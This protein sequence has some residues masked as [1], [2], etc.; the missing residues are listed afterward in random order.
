MSRHDW[1]A[2]NPGCYLFESLGG[3]AQL[4]ARLVRIEKAR[5]SS[6]LTSTS[7]HG[8][9]RDGPFG[10]S[11]PVRSSQIQRVNQIRCS[12]S[13]WVISWSVHTGQNHANASTTSTT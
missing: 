9:S 13:E 8:P 11:A 7:T 6:P 5:G 2:P 4:V 10:I 3:V 12:H 1:E